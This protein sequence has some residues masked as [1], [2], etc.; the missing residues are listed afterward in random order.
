M[1]K[2]RFLF[3]LAASAF[4]A[5]LLQAASGLVLWLMPHR[6]GRGGGGGDTGSTFI[7][8]R[9]TWIDIHEWTAVVLLILIAIHIYMHWGW[10]LRQAKALFK[11][12]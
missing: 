4:L 7:W 8:G 3:I 6:G 12:K 9:Q 1:S 2:T 10:L 5:M 11:T